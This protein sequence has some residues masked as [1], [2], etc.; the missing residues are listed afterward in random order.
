[1][2]NVLT[3]L[4]FWLTLE[5]QR[6]RVLFRSLFV[7]HF[8]FVLTDALSCSNQFVKF[9][10]LKLSI[11]FFLPNKNISVLIFRKVSL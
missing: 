5:A 10:S 1:M 4:V 7:S 2:C 3:L 6:K 11:H 9:E 8:T